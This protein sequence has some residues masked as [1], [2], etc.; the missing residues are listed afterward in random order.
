MTP[1]Q[2]FY[3]VSGDAAR[4]NPAL[5]TITDGLVAHRPAQVLQE[6]VWQEVAELLEHGVRTFHVDVNF[7]DYGGF[8]HRRPD[9]NVSLFTPAFL[10]RLNT[11]VRERDAFLNLHLL[12]DAP[13]A[14]L[15]DYAGVG[16]GAVCFQL[17]AVAAPALEALVEEIRATGAVASP[18]I[19]TVGSVN[20]PAE[21]V[22][23][24][25]A[26]LEPVLRR[27]GMLT[28]QAVGTGARSSWSS[29]EAGQARLRSYATWIRS[30]FEGTLQIQGGI[31]T[32]TVGKMVELG[33]DFLVCGTQIF[34]NPGGLPAHEVVAALIA[35]AGR[36]L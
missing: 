12:T 27:V 4:I 17:E 31:T 16:A 28:L 2:R 33:A 10:E 19:E 15:R 20:R 3:G 9:L 25:L 23:A 1:A 6:R 14:R 22:D 29:P 8:V 7:P 13:R 34:R 35:E 5:I 36:A 26:K 11:F 24:V 30:N 18:V 21:P 32:A